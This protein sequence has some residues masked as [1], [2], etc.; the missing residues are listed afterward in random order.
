MPLYP[1]KLDPK[2]YEDILKEVGQ[3]IPFYTPEWTNNNI[4]DQEQA[5]L[6][7]YYANGVEF[8]KTR[9]YDLAIVEFSKALKINPRIANAYAFRGLCYIARG[10]YDQAISDASKAVGINP[11]L[12]S[13]HEIL[14]LGYFGKRKFDKALEAVRKARCLGYKVNAN[15]L[16]NLRKA[17]GRK[18]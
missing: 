5:K 12:A 9:Q 16:R 13:A 15:F 17:S 10:E 2:E 7:I 8:F 4:Q 1:P 14:A 6:K 3:R 18:N 11:K